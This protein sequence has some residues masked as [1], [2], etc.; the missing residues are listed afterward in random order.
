MRD[1]GTLA[2]RHCTHLHLL[3]WLLLWLI[4]I[5]VGHGLARGHGRQVSLAFLLG[6]APHEPFGNNED[7][8]ENEDDSKD[9]AD[10]CAKVKLVL[11]FACAV[12][13]CRVGA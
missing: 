11:A 1:D 8:D 10:D 12:K 6:P 7:A 3:L 13:T 5:G 9:G 2:H 4:C